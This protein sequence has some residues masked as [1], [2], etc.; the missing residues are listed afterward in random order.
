MS[1]DAPKPETYNIMGEHSSPMS[2]PRPLRQLQDLALSPP[3]KRLALSNAGKSG[4]VVP[5]R[6]DEMDD[7]SEPRA[8]QVG[9]VPDANTETPLT[10]PPTPTVPWF[11]A[12]LTSW[13]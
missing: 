4:P 11:M 1:F 12:V 8:M 2:P 9:M 7:D 5:D 10:V 13:F 6:N 3:K